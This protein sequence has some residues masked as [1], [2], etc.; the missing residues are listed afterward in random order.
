MGQNIRN[1]TLLEWTQDILDVPGRTVDLP[2]VGSS[3]VI[4]D[5]ID[6]I[7]AVMSTQVGLAQFAIGCPLIENSSSISEKGIPTIR[8]GV[9]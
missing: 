5:N 8:F 6:N 1:N 3:I 7:K 9:A 4:T 2:L